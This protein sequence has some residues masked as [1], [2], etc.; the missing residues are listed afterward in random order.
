MGPAAD[1]SGLGIAAALE[2]SFSRYTGGESL[3]AGR[4]R[5][6]I[7]GERRSVAVLFLDLA[8]FTDLGEVLDH[9]DLHGIISRIMGFLSSVVESFGGY[10]DK[11]EGDRLMALFGARSAGE[12][13]SARAV[14]CALR[15]LDILEEVGP[16][17]PAGRK[18][19]AR[20]G[21]HFGPVTV[22]PDPT[23]HLT[24]TGSTV[25]LAS[26][27]EEMGE[28]GKVC[29]SVSV[30]RECGDLFDFSDLG[31]FDVRGVSDPVRLHVPLGPGRLPL[32]RWERASRLNGA[33][34]VDRCSEKTVLME[35]LERAGSDPGG[36]VLL[37]IRGI[38]GIGKSRLLHHLIESADGFTVL[39]GH[40]GHHL[41][42]PFW[43]F[44]DMLRDHFG[45]TDEPTEEI[46]G[47]I[48]KLA[49]D[50]SDVKL[51]EKVLQESGRMTELLSLGS[52][53]TG[54]RTSEASGNTVVAI[55]LVLDA[56]GTGGPLLMALEDVHWMDEPSAR[57]LQL[58]V[59]SGAGSSS[60]LIAATERPFEADPEVWTDDWR[61][62]E[63]D[64]LD[65][66]DIGSISGFLLAGESGPAELSP[67]L[68]DLLSRGARGI[69]FYAE[70][71]V[72]SLLEIGEI[73]SADGDRWHLKTGWDG[74]EVPSAVR[75]LIQSRVD[76][77]P[78]EE[79]K[80]LQ[81]A[82]VIGATFS[83]TVL[84][85]VTGMLELEI[86][87]DRI[88]DSLAA[89]G[90]IVRRGRG[91]MDFRHDLVQSS[92]YRTVLRHNRRMVHALTAEVCEELY[93][94]EAGALAPV[95]FH[96][97]REAEERG[98]ILEWAA[99]ALKIAEVND[100]GNEI[101]GITATILELVGE[102]PVDGEWRIMCDALMARSNILIRDGDM[103]GA[104][105]LIDTVLE[106]SR[107][108]REPWLEAAA[109]RSRLTL[110]HETGRLAGLE[111]SF[112]LALKRAREAD[113][114]NLRASIHSSVANIYSDMSEIEKALD[115]YRKARDIYT[116]NGN[117]R[118]LA[119]V[120]SN[121]ANLMIRMGKPDLAEEE[122][123]NAIGIYRELGMRA[124]LGYGLN[125]YAIL[126][127]QNGELEE[128][129][130]LFE[131]ALEHQVDIG[132]K[133]LQASILSNL[134][135]LY[136]LL[137]DYDASLKY[138]L[139]ALKM[140]R[141]AGDMRTKAI[142]L[143][144]LGNIYRLMGEHAKALEHSE[145]SL[146]LSTQVRDSVTM[147]HA[148]SVMGMALLETDDP[149]GAISMYDKALEIVEEKAIISGIIDDF[150]ELMDMLVDRG[151][152]FRAPSHWQSEARR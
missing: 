27:I 76:M 41:L 118:G 90:Y 134:G 28:T 64:A 24:A 49:N 31:S 29:V 48:E 32:E 46:R 52:R 103:T 78:G 99:R 58:F 121:M 30:R 15:M 1:A 106:E 97:W 95:I 26:R 133:G 107:A 67:E 22:A 114:E 2:E 20:V 53:G 92:V 60:T 109:M 113:D 40:A 86:D 148:L 4:T 36:T 6:L 70:E 59:E 123:R 14:G 43:I 84:E 146:R 116:G 111:G 18:I 65:S 71:L 131:E 122:Y 69:P 147:C 66:G 152:E 124:S 138:R 3:L 110:L 54:G 10:V 137:G 140:A 51:G 142:A 45:I 25:N 135:V 130:R 129:G 85:R 93:A 144:N 82:S 89:K 128:A 145:E 108:R 87:L 17:L 7:E 35:L 132:N 150:E 105:E 68:F 125:G 23:G 5:R 100:Q 62:L 101:L 141:K 38:A 98:K 115:H 112:E 79:R 55:R 44:I 19:S 72:L 151:I 34:M 21:I 8:G 77:L 139:S 75:S 61:V 102:E 11:F 80:L 94:D 74:M 136:R 81:L 104:L 127:A 73:E 57:V 47:R 143:V 50:C 96:H 42:T 88:I 126:K 117:I 9:E 91:T 120:M 37:R 16:V 63:L 56:I 83:V 13:D 12:N 33:P 149:A 119:A 39:H